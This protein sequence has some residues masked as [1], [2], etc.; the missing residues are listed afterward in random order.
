MRIAFRDRT[1]SISVRKICNFDEKSCFFN[2]KL[3]FLKFFSNPI[4]ENSLAKSFI[5]HEK[6][7][8]FVL[9]CS[10][11][12]TPGA[13]KRGAKMSSFS[14]PRCIF[15]RSVCAFFDVFPMFFDYF[16]G[17]DYSMPLQNFRV[18]WGWCDGGLTVRTPVEHCKKTR[19]FH[20]FFRAQACESGNDEKTEWKFCPRTSFCSSV[21]TI[22][23]RAGISADEKRRKPRY[24]ARER[25]RETGEKNGL[26]ARLLRDRMSS[27]EESSGAKPSQAKP[28]IERRFIADLS[29]VW[30][31]FILTS[32]F[33][34]ILEEC[35]L[36][37]RFISGE[38]R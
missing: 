6:I 38:G 36:S 24:R 29:A 31:L 27:I 1:C 2:E 32:M 22:W 13:L 3:C 26:L 16:S 4:C 19:F 33:G 5:F 12:D 21:V 11:K 37:P 20:V 25:E 7:V 8:F 18:V 15:G 35:E 34:L 30:G 10:P 17:P 28:R 14:R 23:S 9:F